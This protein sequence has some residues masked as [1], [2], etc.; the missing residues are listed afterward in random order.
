MT[1]L[2]MDV[3]RI[4]RIFAAAFFLWLGGASADGSVQ[5]IKT[6]GIEYMT[7][8]FGFDERRE[9]GEAAKG[10]N[11]KTIGDYLADVTDDQH[12]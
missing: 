8:G 6:D 7:G 4:F 2:I 10:F 12:H 11:L 1:L 9:M 3:P 5:T